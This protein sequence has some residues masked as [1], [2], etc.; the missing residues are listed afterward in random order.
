VSH[1]LVHTGQHYDKTMSKAFFDELDIPEP[2]INIGVESGTHAEQVGHT[3]IGFEN[4]PNPEKR[5]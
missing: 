3:M 4:V 2:D 5:Y 1:I